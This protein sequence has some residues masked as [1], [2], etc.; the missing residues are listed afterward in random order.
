M[1]MRVG[2]AALVGVVMTAA[3]VLLNRGHLLSFLHGLARGSLA[4]GS[5]LGSVLQGPAAF[6]VFGGAVVAV[7]FA[8]RR[9]RDIRA[10]LAVARSAVLVGGVVGSV[11]GFTVCAWF[12]RFPIKLGIPVANA[13]ISMF[14]AF[15]AQAFVLLPLEAALIARDS[16]VVETPRAE[17][18][19]RFGGAALKVMLIALLSPPLVAVLGKFIGL[20]PE[21]FG[22]DRFIMLL[23][24]PAALL[25]AA[26]P[27]RVGSRFGRLLCDS[28]LA[29]GGVLLI[30]SVV[31][32][33]ENVSRGDGMGFPRGAAAIA[34]ALVA[35]SFAALL[36]PSAVGIEDELR[37]ERSSFR[38][39]AAYFAAMSYVLTIGII[40]AISIPMPGTKHSDSSASAVDASS[41]KS[42]ASWAPGAHTNVTTSQIAPPH[43]SDPAAVGVD[44]IVVRQADLDAAH[45][46]RTSFDVVF[47]DAAHADALRAHYA[48]LIDLSILYLSNVKHADTV[49]E[50]NMQ[51]LQAALLKRVKQVSGGENA[52]RI[53]FRGFVSQ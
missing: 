33:L 49:G 12:V 11:I 41:N 40:A 24:G 32:F 44:D 36:F 14:Y 43:S 51:K 45:Y 17:Q 20:P 9:T 22:Q 53:L 42:G 3:S 35:A 23:V 46:I 38:A 30:D 50:E 5:D 39:Y 31:H 7:A 48:E 27:L 28:F 13:V 25:I 8:A 18:F 34:S 19:A 10:L 37:S 26:S 47:A 21:V 6:I 16:G 29:S 52:Q 2:L 1:K 15:A 4:D